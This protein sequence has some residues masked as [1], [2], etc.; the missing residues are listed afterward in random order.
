MATAL[1]FRQKAEQCRRLASAI[2]TRNDPTAMALQALAVEFD[3]R[4]KALE[5]ETAAALLI[6]YGDDIGD[7]SAPATNGDGKD[8]TAK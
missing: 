3:Q 2:L 8:N 6:G 5:S 7:H 4:A 1:Y